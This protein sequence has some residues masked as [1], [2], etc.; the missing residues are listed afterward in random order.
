MIE[1]AND[2]NNSFGKYLKL[3]NRSASDLYE[4]TAGEIESRDVEKRLNYSA[5]QR[6]N[7]RPDIDRTDVVLAEDTSTSYSLSFAENTNNNESKQ[8]IQLINE[9][10]DKISNNRVF[11]VADDAAI[12]DFS[13]KPIM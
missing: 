13:K 11:D 9:N 7:T 3:K 1:Y 5:E 6:K 4:S 10:A 8:I 12:N 2:R